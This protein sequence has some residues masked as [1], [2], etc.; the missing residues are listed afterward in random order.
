M[1]ITHFL[2]V[3]SQEKGIFRIAIFHVLAQTFEKMSDWNCVEQRLVYTNMFNML[4]SACRIK[5]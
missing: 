3:T 5:Y 4:I 2:V 1:I